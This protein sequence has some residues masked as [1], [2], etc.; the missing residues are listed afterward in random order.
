M[1]RKA[2]GQEKIGIPQMEAITEVIDRIDEID[3]PDFERRY[4]SYYIDGMTG[5]HLLSQIDSALDDDALQHIDPK[6]VKFINLVLLRDHIRHNAD[7]IR[8]EKNHGWV[9]EIFDPILS[10]AGFVNINPIYSSSLE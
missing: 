1:D 6:E 3:W 2:L 8:T 5:N 4:V 7:V 10:K 9:D